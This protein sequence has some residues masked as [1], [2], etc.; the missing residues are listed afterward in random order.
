V[1]AVLG[2]LG[3]PAGR[4]DLVEPGAT[5]YCEMVGAA[6]AARRPTTAG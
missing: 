6:L 4:L 1:L 2:W 3:L 5:A